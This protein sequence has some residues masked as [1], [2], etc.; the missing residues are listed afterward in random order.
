M[1]HPSLSSLFTHFKYPYCLT[2]SKQKAY[3]SQQYKADEILF[4]LHLTL[5]TMDNEYEMAG[6]SIDD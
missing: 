3:D 1:V 5:D 6:K 2:F 4:D